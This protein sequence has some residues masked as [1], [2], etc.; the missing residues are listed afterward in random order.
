MFREDL[1]R[2]ITSFKLKTM[3]MLN[4]ITT[5]LGL[6]C[7]VI[8]YK[9]YVLNTAVYCKERTRF[10]VVNKNR[11][12]VSAWVGYLSCRFYHASG[13]WNRYGTNSIPPEI[14]RKIGSCDIISLV[15]LSL[16]NN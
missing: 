4:F 8:K 12:Y 6:Y 16:K 2:Q 5:T 9:T 1:S 3:K 11:S 7:L 13:H 10:V 15:V 14:G